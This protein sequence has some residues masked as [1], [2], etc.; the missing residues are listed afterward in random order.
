MFFTEKQIWLIWL[1]WDIFINVLTVADGDLT[2]CKGLGHVCRSKGR[3]EK[4]MPTLT[5]A[6][7]SL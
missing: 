2:V 4:T 6:A 7:S 3:A 5:R 1:P